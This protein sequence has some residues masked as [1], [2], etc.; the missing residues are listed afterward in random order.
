MKA[1]VCDKCGKVVLIPDNG[2]A[3]C[4][5]TGIYR[6]VSMNDGNG[7]V[8]LCEECKKELMDA[9]RRNVDEP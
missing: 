3:F 5:E 4:T 6:L 8:D 1:I 7:I 9:V 2:P